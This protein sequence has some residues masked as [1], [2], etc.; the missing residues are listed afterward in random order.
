M[1]DDAAEFLRSAWHE[2]GDIDER[3]NRNIEGIAKA[4]KSCGLD[5]AF[6]IQAPGQDQR[7]IGN[8]ANSLSSHSCKT[9]QNIFGVVRLEF[10]E[11]SVI[12]SFK[13]EL[14]HVIWHIGV[15]GNQ[16]V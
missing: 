15:I 14:L 6:D 1:L 8:N 7:L 12:H 9:N 13:N 5:T 3:N 2:A 11:V 10:K 16:A 4:D